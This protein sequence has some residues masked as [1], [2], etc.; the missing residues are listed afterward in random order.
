MG[1]ASVLLWVGENK[2]SPPRN[3]LGDPLAF[4]VGLDRLLL[5]A[6][7]QPLQKALLGRNVALQGDG[8]KVAQPGDVGPAVR[9]VNL[10]PSSGICRSVTAAKELCAPVSWS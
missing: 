9:L 4:W 6:M 3:A 5:S 10:N 1:R 2:V 8:A 7:S